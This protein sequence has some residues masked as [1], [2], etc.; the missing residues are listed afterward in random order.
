MKTFLFSLILLL[1]IGCNNKITNKHIP[2]HNVD[3]IKKG[4]IFKTKESKRYEAIMKKFISGKINTI[5]VDDSLLSY[6]VF[7]LDTYKFENLDSLRLYYVDYSINCSSFE[8][9]P[10]DYIYFGLLE[11]DSI[12]FSIK[13]KYDYDI[14]PKRY[15]IMNDTILVIG[16]TYKEVEDKI[17]KYNDTVLIT[18][19]VKKL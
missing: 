3:I 4:E 5:C 1:T 2:I 9:G 13:N 15:K 19:Y 14:L 6:E 16:S 11:N 8:D 18:K 7:F 10:Y 12:I 17:V